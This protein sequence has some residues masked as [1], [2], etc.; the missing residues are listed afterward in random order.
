MKRNATIKLTITAF[1]VAVNIVGAYIALIL[2]LPIY[3]DSIG[4]ILSSVLL[5]PVYG[6]ATAAIAGIIS[7]VTSDVYAFY[8]LPVGMITGLLAG[9]LYRAG[10]YRRWKFP[11]GVLF[12]TVPGTVV[13]SSI[14]AFVFGGVTS[15]GSSIIVQVLS[16]LG[17]GLVASAFIVQILTDYLDRLISVGIVCL[18]TLRLGGRVRQLL[19]KGKK[20]G[21]V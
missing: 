1:C 13:S 2:R 4:T 15:S 18:V 11:L 5:G 19:E 12:L 8:F 17:L 7:G 3:L 16:H 21:A 14:S 6:F 10:W 9:I 20:H